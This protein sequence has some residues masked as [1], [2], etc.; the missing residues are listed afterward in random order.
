MFQKFT[1]CVDT[2]PMCSIHK[3]TCNETSFKGT[4]NAYQLHLEGKYK[5]LK[6]QCNV[7]LDEGVVMQGIGLMGFDPIAL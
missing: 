6:V 5:S 1:G 4:N 7:I 3:L 2:G